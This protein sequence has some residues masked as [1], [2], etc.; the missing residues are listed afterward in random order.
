VVVELYCKHHARVR[1]SGA[2]NLFY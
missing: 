1:V 2:R